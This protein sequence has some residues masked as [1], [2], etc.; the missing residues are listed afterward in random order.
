MT[1]PWTLRAAQSDPQGFCADAVDNNN[2]QSDP[3]CTTYPVDYTSAN[4]I[5]LTVFQGTASPVGTVFAN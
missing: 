4:L 2:L 1:L 5:R 3:W